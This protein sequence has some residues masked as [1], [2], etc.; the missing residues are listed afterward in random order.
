MRAIPL[1]AVPN[2]R[3][4]FMFEQSAYTA[5]IVTR[6]DR[7]YITVWQDGEMVLSN[8]SLCSYAPLVNGLVLADTEG[9]DDPI[10][11]G[12]GARWQL[13]VV[14]PDELQ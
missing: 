13:F 2:Q 5:E 10:Y 11:E 12:L 1:S 8:R 4:S 6:R 7:L 14:S 9:T 3:V